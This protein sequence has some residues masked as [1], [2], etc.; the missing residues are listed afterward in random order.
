MGV[1]GR[2]RGWVADGIKRRSLLHIFLSSCINSSLTLS[3]LL[4][5]EEIDAGAGR[6]TRKQRQRRQVTW[7]FLY[8]AD[9]AILGT[10]VLWIFGRATGIHVPRWAIVVIIL[11]PLTFIKLK[12]FIRNRGRI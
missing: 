12:K 8:I 9:Q 1:L 3:L 5:L 11:G 10:L 6:I 2:V 7:T 4:V